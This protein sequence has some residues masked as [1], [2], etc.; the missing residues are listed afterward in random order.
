MAQTLNICTYATLFALIISIHFPITEGRKIKTM[1][2]Q[3]V[4]AIK[5]HSQRHNRSN[6]V[7]LQHKNAEENAESSQPAIATNPIT[8]SD[9][10][11][12]AGKQELFP[13]ITQISSP[14]SSESTSEYDQND[15]RPTTPGTSPGVGHPLESDEID[16]K[17]SSAIHSS[18]NHFISEQNDEFRP[19]KPGHSPGVGHVFQTKIVEP[20]E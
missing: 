13:R 17:V 4:A 15:F 11:S 3:E 7:N 20:R 19:T 14:V 1:K 2:K 18:T 16:T 12:L 6:T 8:P 5:E 9:H 10:R